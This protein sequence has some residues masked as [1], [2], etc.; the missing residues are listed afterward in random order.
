M[1]KWIRIVIVILV[2]ILVAAGAFVLNKSHEQAL[3][4]I[5]PG[6][7][8]SR[9][10]ET[11]ADYRL[12]YQDLTLTTSDGVQLAAWYVPTQNGAV[13]IAQHGY[14][15]NRGSM[16][17]YASLLA[18]HGYGVLMMDARAHG[19][20]GGDMV[21]F[22]LKEVDD[23]RAGLDF[24]LTRPEI[25]PQKIGALGTSQGAVTLMLAAAQFPEIRAYMG[26]S[27]YASLEEEVAKG[28]QEIAG[29]PA[30]PWAPLIRMFAERE[31]GFTAEV[32]APINNIDEI[33]PRPI[34]LLQGGQDNLVPAD[35]GERLLE[36]AGDPKQLWYEEEIG[37]TE[38]LDQM[39]EQ[40][41]QIVIGF[42]DQY[43]L[44]K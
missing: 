25:D 34:L 11:P 9:A 35:T 40:Y 29:M 43:L 8:R 41:E 2:L 37:H 39:P 7:D 32:V 30:F 4:F 1:K 28:V 36:A 18:E 31:A 33:S 14:R 3:W 17:K 23:V 6:S 13:I 22:G 15:S 10:E 19:D 42:F 27:P 21:T 38:F 16:L 20:S 24:L 44:G 12:E 5:H 26:D